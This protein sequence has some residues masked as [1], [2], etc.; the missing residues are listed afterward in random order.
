MLEA[1][2]TVA[3]LDSMTEREVYLKELSRE[4]DISLDAL[5]QDCN[6]FRMQLQK[7]GRRG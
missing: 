5:K 7:N 4:F 6:R 3:E 1:V 2:R